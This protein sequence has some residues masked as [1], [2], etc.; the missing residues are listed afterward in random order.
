MIRRK[1][2]SHPARSGAGEARNE[3]PEAGVAEEAGV[4]VAGRLSGRRRIP[5]RRRS[6]KYLKART[7]SEK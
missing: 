2:Q 4:G 3:S 7:T 6:Q 5:Q 1:I